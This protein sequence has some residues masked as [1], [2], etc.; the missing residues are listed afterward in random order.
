MDDTIKQ[1]N[2][3]KKRVD[4]LEKDDIKDFMLDLH[5]DILGLRNDVNLLKDA[6]DKL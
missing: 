1:L 6:L 3:L 2:E 4:M 5:N